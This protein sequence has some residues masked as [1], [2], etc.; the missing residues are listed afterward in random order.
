MIA[1]GLIDQINPVVWQKDWNVN[2]QPVGDA[3]ASLKYLTPYVFRVGISDSRIVSVED[4]FVTFKYWKKKSSRP[5][6]MRLDVF[7]L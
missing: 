2:C 5:R 3:E 6:T 4:G 7:E 1:A